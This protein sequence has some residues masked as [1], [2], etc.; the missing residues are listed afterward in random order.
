MARLLE[1]AAKGDVHKIEECL[2]GSL[3]HKAIE[4]NW[5]NA[6][7]ESALYE[8]ARKDQIEAVRALLKAGA[9]P[10]LACN[11]DGSTPLHTPNNVEIFRELLKAGANVNAT[12][13]NGETPLFCACHFANAEVVEVLLAANNTT[14]NVARNDG[15]T[16]LWIA[17]QV[18]KLDV[19]RLLIKA[20]ANLEAATTSNAWTPLFVACVWGR[21]EVVRELINSKANLEATEKQNSGTPLYVL[22][23]FS[24]RRCCLSASRRA[25]ADQRRGESERHNKDREHSAVCCLP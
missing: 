11:N 22:T 1:A 13:K 5:Q 20:G 23:G 10:N 18:G 9:N 2:K 24:H 7:G 12:K 6:N 25:R 17:S 3:F 15:A 8:A 19:V 14:V 21:D 4:V 16:P